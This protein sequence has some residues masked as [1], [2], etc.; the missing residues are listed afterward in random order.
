MSPPASGTPPPRLTL[1]KIVSGDAT[2]VTCSGFLTAPYA[3]EL[4]AYV[5]EILPDIKRIVLDLSQ[6]VFMDS[7]GLGTIV[8]LYI[9]AK[10]ARSELQVVH[11]S[12]QIR[13]LFQV[14]RV[15]SLFECGGEYI[16]MKLP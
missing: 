11:L 7:S 2:V 14:T 3:P 1:S 5:R 9:S 10:A 16:M 12:K 13:E 15:L 6:V 4:K 8:A